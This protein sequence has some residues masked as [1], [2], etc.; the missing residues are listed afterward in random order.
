[1]NGLADPA[2][3]HLDD[4]RRLASMRKQG[5]AQVAAGRSIAP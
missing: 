2:G 4:M 3:M 1:M 5:T